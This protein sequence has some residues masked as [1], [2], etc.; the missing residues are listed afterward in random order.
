MEKKILYTVFILFLTFYGCKKDAVP[1]QTD[2]P[3]VILSEVSDITSEGVTFNANITCLGNQNIL[4]FG[5]IWNEGTAEPNLNSSIKS[6]GSNPDLGNFSYRLSNDL[7]KGK[8]YNVGAYIKT[9]K[10]VF[11]SNT[12][13]FTSEGCLPPMI[14][15]FYPDSISEGQEVTIIGKNFSTKVSNNKVYF[16]TIQANLVKCNTDTIVVQCPPILQTMITN[17]TVKVADHQVI[18]EGKI[19]LI[20]PWERLKVFPGGNRSGSFSFVI[21]D[22][23]YAA[24]G[25]NGSSTF[26]TSELWQYDSSLDQWETKSNFPGPPRNVASAFSIN[27]KGYV[28]FGTDANKQHLKDLWEYDPENDLW[29]QKAVFPGNAN[30]SQAVLLLNNKAYFINNDKELWSY[31]PVSDQ[32]ILVK[33]NTEAKDIK[34]AHADQGTGYILSSDGKLW[35][36]DSNANSFQLNS[37]LQVGSMIGEDLVRS[38]YLKDNFYFAVYPCWIGYNY[39]TKKTIQYFDWP[40]DLY[41]AINIMFCFDDKV[42][43][44]KTLNSEFWVYSP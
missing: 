36:Y 24:S 22:K 17:I 7:K 35:Q 39:R 31:E 15:N 23:G 29:V 28:C 38:F 1:E 5:F 26:A 14:R 12:Q 27:G 20:N 42:F 34:V 19:T 2:Y 16:G 33:E 30:F 37:Q 32:W 43:F 10:V 25:K 3:F 4:D 11:Y 6:L 8:S 13:L 44:S 21:G 41:N 9:D 18:S 40:F